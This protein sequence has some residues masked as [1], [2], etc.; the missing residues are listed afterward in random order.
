MTQTQT[1]SRGNAVLSKGHLH[2]LGDAVVSTVRPEFGTLRVEYIRLI[3]CKS[4]MNYY[5]ITCRCVDGGTV[6]GAERFFVGVN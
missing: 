2:G 4:I 1:I 5:R 6:E 3:E